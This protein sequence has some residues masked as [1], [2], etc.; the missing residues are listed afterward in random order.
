MDIKSEVMNMVSMMCYEGKIKSS[1]HIRLLLINFKF[2][3]RTIYKELLHD[4]IIAAKD[5]LIILLKEIPEILPFEH[6]DPPE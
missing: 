1:I 6:E 5:K 4:M 3:F 2:V